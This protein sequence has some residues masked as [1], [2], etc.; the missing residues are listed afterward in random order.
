MKE[1]EFGIRLR[2]LREAKGLTQQEAANQI[3][4]SYRALQRHEYGFIPNMNN[5]E[6]YAAFYRVEK[7]WLLTGGGESD[8][9]EQ[10]EKAQNEAVMEEEPVYRSSADARNV[11]KEAVEKLHEILASGDVF[12]IQA[13]LSNLNA[14]EV[15]IS[16]S[17]TLREKE[18]EIA[19]LQRELDETKK[20]VNDLRLELSRRA[21][22]TIKV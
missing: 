10:N 11:L 22:E 17:A 1:K 13:I 6:K 3:P 21:E 12:A 16:I 14:L 8:S 7:F 19:T 5:L 18:R 2:Q 20:Q 4:I 9:E 15:K